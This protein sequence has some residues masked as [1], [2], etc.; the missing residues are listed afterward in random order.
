MTINFYKITHLHPL[1][2]EI[3]SLYESAFPR[4]ERRDFEVFTEILKNDNRFNIRAGIDSDTGN[5]IDFISYWDFGSFLYLEHF[6][7]VENL[8]SHGIGKK[9]LAD[10]FDSMNKRAI[11]EVEPPTDDIARR[12]IAF[13][14]SFG[15][16]LLSDYHYIQ[17][18]YAP[19]LNP[20]ELKLMTF[21]EFTTADVDTAVSSIKSA[22]YGV[23]N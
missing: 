4:D 14:E 23:K 7:V 15:M 8:R 5:L 1:M 16:K 12:R 20:L 17:P 9:A 19:H 18:P 22:V 6:A 3:K 21:G 13:Y 11:F 10:F 2:A